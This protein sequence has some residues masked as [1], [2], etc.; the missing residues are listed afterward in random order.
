VAG[1]ACRRQRRPGVL[2]AAGGALAA[3]AA[4]GAFGLAAA[5]SG[6][7]S[8]AGLGRA[9]GDLSV[10]GLRPSELVVPAAHNIVLGTRLDTV[11]DTHAHGSHP[12]E[13]TNYPRPLTFA[14]DV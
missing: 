14:L 5:V 11:W 13:V 4:A 8:G 6:T 7:D 3:F 9:V 1:G 2:L 10:F 12:P